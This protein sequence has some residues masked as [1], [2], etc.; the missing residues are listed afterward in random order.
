MTTN[1][2]ITDRRPTEADGDENGEVLLRRF[3]DGRKDSTTRSTDALID[4]RHVGKGVPWQHTSIWQPPSKRN[5]M[6]ISNNQLAAI[7]YFL[8][9]IVLTIAMHFMSD[10]IGALILLVAYGL[11]GV[12][13]GFSLLAGAPTP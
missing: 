1:D 4:W 12:A 2:W 6:P 8:L 5:T 11:T 7:L 3:A 10:P 9:A 13:I